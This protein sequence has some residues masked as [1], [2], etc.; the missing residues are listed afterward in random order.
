[1]TNP[2]IKGTQIMKT[3]IRSSR[4]VGFV[5]AAALVCVLALPNA[6]AQMF[7]SDELNRRTLERRAV[8]AAIWGMPI[9]NMD[10]MRQAFFSDAGATYGDVV[11]IS[12]PSDWKFLV[13]TPNNSTRYIYIN[14]Y[15]NYNTTEGP[16]VIEVPASADGAELF[17]TFTDAWNVPVLDIGPTGADQGKGGKYL[18]LPPGF[19][20][21][22]PAGYIPVRSQTYNGYLIPRAITKSSSEADTDA[23]IGLVKQLKLY[24][25]SQAANPPPTRYIDMTGKVFDGIVKFDESFYTS[26]ARM[27]NEEP[28]LPRDKQMLG[29]LRTLGIEKGKEFKPDAAT[30][31]VLK[32]AINEAH[33]WFMD[34]LA[35]WGQ[36]FWPGRRWEVS[37]APIAMTTGFKWEAANYFAVDERGIGYFS[38]CAIPAK[39]GAATF[40]LGTFHDAAD[41]RL[42]GENTY[43]L[44]VPPNV[45]AKQFWAVTV[46]S[47]EESTFIRD[48]VRQSIDSYDQKVKKNADGS[49]DIYFGPKPPAGQEANWIPTVAGKG[50]FPFFRFYGPDKPLFEKTWKLPDIEKVK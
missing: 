34:K 45:P 36:R 33:A 37:V 20:G 44:R 38:F 22:V 21:E 25:L 49:V 47:H 19:K 43:R 50:W 4:F 29:M 30:Q 39:L 7:S 16:V 1:M 2:K 13:T 17:G 26:L 35:T 5:L 40:Y 12:R 41:H 28:V 32:Q 15:I 14:Y 18:L 31:A 8:E 24:P 46:Y 23:A 6:H 3:T 9:V 48:S 42:R 10:A 11:Y 27:V